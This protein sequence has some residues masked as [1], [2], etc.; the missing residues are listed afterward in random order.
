MKDYLIYENLVSEFKEQLVSKLRLHGS[1]N[2]I[3]SLWVPDDDIVK[4]FHNLIS[5]LNEIKR[6]AF[7]R[8]V[9]EGII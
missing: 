3:L 7:A 4:S 2:E 5:A 8:P 1:E 6:D 9:Q